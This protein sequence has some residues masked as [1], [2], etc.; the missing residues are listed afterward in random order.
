MDEYTNSCE[1]LLA[2]DSL[3]PCLPL[4]Q[5]KMKLQLQLSNSSVTKEEEKEPVLLDVE[6]LPKQSCD[7]CAPTDESLQLP[8]QTSLSPLT[9]PDVLL[10]PLTTYIKSFSHD[11]DSSNHTQSSLDTTFD[12]ISS[13]KPGLMDEEDHEEEDDR[14]EFVDTLGFF[15]SHTI[16]MEPL[17]FGGKLTLDAVKIDFGDFFQNSNF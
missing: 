7:I 4:K 13:H 14:E 9:E 2:V 17:E 8:P 10:Y 12:Y 6:E 15:P 5:G 3:R 11:S 1:L 16:V